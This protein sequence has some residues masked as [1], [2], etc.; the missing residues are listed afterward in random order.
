M[1]LIIIA[2]II[3]EKFT[4]ISINIFLIS[5]PL[6]NIYRSMPLPAIFMAQNTISKLNASF[7]MLCNTDTITDV[8]LYA[9]ISV[10]VILFQFHNW[11]D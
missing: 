5:P 3:I 11:C 8:I 1:F 2:G 4:I 6:R 9:I 7:M 10:F